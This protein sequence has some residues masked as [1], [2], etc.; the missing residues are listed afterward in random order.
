MPDQ[1]PEVAGGDKRGGD[2]RGGDRRRVDRRAPPPPWR[3]PWAF[4]GYGAGAVLVLVLLLRG[5]GGERNTPGVATA[6][7]APAPAPV[8]TAH[9][10]QRPGQVEPAMSTGDYERLT[11]EGERAVGRIVKAQLYCEPPQQVALE[12]ATA[13]TVEAPI[14]AIRDSV[15]NRVSAAD[16]KWGAQDDPRRGDFLLVVPPQ[17]AAEF[18]SQPVALDGFVRR[19]RLIANVE[20]IGRS[21]ALALQTVGIFRGLS[22]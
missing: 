9:T 13:D 12:T 1:A 17:L 19:R 22:R 8:D 15:T 4:A 20:W 21:R 16:C 3:T 11:L 6:P 14:A 2:R 18:A 5:C 7:V 10:P